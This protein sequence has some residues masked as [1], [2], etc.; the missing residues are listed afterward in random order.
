MAAIGCHATSDVHRVAPTADICRRRGKYGV[1]LPVY[2]VR[3]EWSP[4]LRHEL[5]C[6]LPL[7]SSPGQGLTSMGVATRKVPS[8]RQSKALTAWSKEALTNTYTLTSLNKEQIADDIV[9]CWTVVSH[10]C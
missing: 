1:G 10:V 2:R 3:W 4:L 8:A 7:S 6:N 5:F 9:Y